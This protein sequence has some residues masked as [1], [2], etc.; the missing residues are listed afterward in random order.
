MLFGRLLLEIKAVVIKG[1]NVDIMRIACVLFRFVMMELVLK[2]F[3]F[4]MML[5]VIDIV[6]GF[7]VLYSVFIIVRMFFVF[8]FDVVFAAG[9]GRILMIIVVRLVCGIDFNKSVVVFG[10]GM[11]F[12]SVL[13]VVGVIVLMVDVLILGLSVVSICVVVL[14]L[15]SNMINRT[16]VSG[17]CILVLECG[18]LMFGG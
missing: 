11:V 5:F 3:I 6:V 15:S 8:M 1:G 2:G 16:L 9:C 17:F 12:V 10:F 7:N 4:E 18:M 13:V 14:G